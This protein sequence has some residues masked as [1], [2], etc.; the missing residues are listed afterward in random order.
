M[1]TASI[2][3]V[4]WKVHPVLLVCSVIYAYKIDI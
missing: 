4:T 2:N 1:L 3:S